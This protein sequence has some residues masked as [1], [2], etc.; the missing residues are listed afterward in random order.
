MADKKFKCDLCNYTGTKPNLASH[1]N[2]VHGEKKHVCT[3]CDYKSTSSS[4]LHRHILQK[5]S[6]EKPISCEKCEYRCV[7]R[8]DMNRHIL[9]MHSDDTP[10][11]CNEKNCNFA[12]KNNDELKRHIIYVHTSEE[13]KIYYNCDRCDYKSTFERYLQI[14]IKEVHGDRDYECDQCDFKTKTKKILDRHIYNIH[15]D[16]KPYKC[17][18]CEY[19]CKTQFHLNIHINRIH[20]DEKP[21]KCQ[22]EGCE[23]SCVL[24]KE[25][26]LHMID[27]NNEYPYKC[28]ECPFECKTRQNLNNHILNIH[29][30]EKNISCD[31]CQFKCK[32]KGDLDHHKVSMHTDIRNFKCDQCDYAGVRKT[33]LYYHILRCHTEIKPVQCD[34]CDD[35]FATN[36]DLNRHIIG[37]HSLER[38]FKCD[39]CDMDFKTPIQLKNHIYNIHQEEKP[40]SCTDCDF[41]CKTKYAL[42]DHFL[43]R[44]NDIRSY[45]CDV[46]NCIDNFKTANCLR[47]HKK[48]IHQKEFIQIHKIEEHKIDVLLKKYEIEFIREHMIDFNCVYDID[49]S[50]AYIDFVLLI[51]NNIIFVEIDEYQHKY[52]Y[53]GIACDMKR[54]S[55]ITESLILG[56]LALPI[57]FIRYNPNSYSVDGKQCRVIQENRQKTLI[58]YIR[59]YKSDP[60]KLLQI[61]YMFYD[62]NNDKL[63][64]HDNEEYNEEFKKCCLDPIY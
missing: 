7:T 13:D 44:H 52:G 14:H 64:L 29:T 60:D 39:K 49:G 9:K 41:R 62:V 27:H 8:E 25:L 43:H 12:C 53:Y 63:K 21:I 16:E 59:N 2:R 45:I 11:K 35:T 30:D 57:L 38:P 28:E 22:E 37:T 54:M 56:G 55:K 36:A 15:S 1:K 17:Q 48:L 61:Q 50:R 19:S 20:I 47:S 23:Y 34:K 51:N 40:F 24:T 42:K 26:R 32:H 6:N 10:I 31:E 18:N 58:E 5:H 4:K 46:G 3:K 33:S